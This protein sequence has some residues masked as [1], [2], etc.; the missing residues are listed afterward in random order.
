MGEKIINGTIERKHGMVK[1]SGSLR[2]NGNVVGANLVATDDITITGNVIDSKVLC[3]NGN[4]SIS[5]GIEGENCYI[6]AFGD[7]RADY[8]IGGKLESRNGSI[9]LQNRIINAKVKAR[10]LVHVFKGDGIIENAVV[11]AGIEVITNILG[12]SNYEPTAVILSNERQQEMFELMLV[13]E[14]KLR[15]KKKKLEQLLKIINIIRLLG[16]NIVNL[17]SE[18]RENLAKQVKEYNIIKQEIEQTNEEKKKVITQNND[19][20]MYT[21]AIIVNEK[22]YPKVSI[23]IDR[24]TQDVVNKYEKVIFYKTGIVIMGDLDQFKLRQR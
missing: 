5:Q 7:I 17:T 8:C 23:T 4:I 11:K 9:Y 2:V 1:I 24:T 21:R 10:N 20:K 19:L 18:K 13:Y 14:N 22:V 3:N 16:E 15:E 12:N 6:E